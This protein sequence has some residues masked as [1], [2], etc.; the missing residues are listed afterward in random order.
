[1]LNGEDPP[2]RPEYIVN[3]IN[4]LER[5]N[6]EAV[7]SL[8]SY[9][10]EQ[11]EQK[12]CDCNAN[13]TL[14]KLYQL[15]PD[16]M[17]DEVVTN[18]LVKAMTQFPSPQFSLAL[19]LINPSVIVQGELAEAVAKLRLLNTQLEGSEYAR[20]W[21]TIDG[22]DL[23]ADLIADISGFEDLIRTNIANL[24]AQAFREVKLS[25]LESWL[26]L[27]SDATAKFVTEV[28]GWTVGDNGIVTVPKNTENEAKKSEIREDVNV[29]MF[30]RVIRRSWEETV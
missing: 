28:A 4:G 22:D 17:K 9:L 15:N 6:P 19:H 23:C 29:D 7:V 2:E 21:N 11:C 5:Y 14:L 3:I 13:R 25:Q 16:R 18:I 10:Q 8:E 27:N 30:S 20:F 24:V 12:Y 1:M 26:G